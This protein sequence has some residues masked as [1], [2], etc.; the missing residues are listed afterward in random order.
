MLSRSLSYVVFRKELR[1][2]LRDKRVLL[3]V[4]ISPLLVTP[5]IL[6]TAAFFVGKKVTNQSAAV[7]D[8]GIV[9]HGAF[10][11]L[12]EK[13]EDD[14][15][16]KTQ[17]FE[18][19]KAAIEAIDKRTVRSV[20]VVSENAQQNF[21]GDQSA[22]LEIIYN[23][24]NENSQNANSRL[25]NI[26]QKF[27]LNALSERV[28]AKALPNSFTKPIDIKN[29]NIASSDSTGAFILGMI[30]PYIIVISAA[31]GGIQTAFDICAGEKERSTMETLLVSPASR[32]QIVLGKLFTIFA[33]SLLASIC[34]MTGVLA[35]L[36]IGLDSFKDILGDQISINLSSIPAMLLIVVPLALFTSSL[37]LVISSFARN[38]KEAQTY[39]LP[40]ISI[41]LLPAM[42]S[43]IFGAETQLYTAF[44]PVMNISLTMKQI[45]GDLFDP[46]YF[47][48]SL[49]SSFLYAYIVM[50][51]ATAFFQR[52]NILFRT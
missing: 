44:I 38:Q 24:A 4:I 43:T 17:K 15:S 2:T 27:S 21:Q 45:L 42:L 1:E 34:A 22:S 10:P 9:E 33:I 5:L 16:I 18:T 35:P 31:F 28:Q 32:P 41:I 25:Q 39:V 37:L 8:I 52:E 3:G 50:R 6:G 12:I 23:L 40:F 19:R 49:G 13:L 20:L 51:I 30:L 7:L 29:T 26:I 36:V 48:I 14:D 46:L 47:A 11:D